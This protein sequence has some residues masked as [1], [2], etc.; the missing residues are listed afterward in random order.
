MSINTEKYIKLIKQQSE[1][2]VW[3][4]KQYD[5]LMDELD[6]VWNNMS[7]EEIDEV[8][9]TLDEQFIKGLDKTQINKL[10]N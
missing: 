2:K 9:K 4:N 3:N 8:Q 10:D 5:R 1:F 7:S 6:K